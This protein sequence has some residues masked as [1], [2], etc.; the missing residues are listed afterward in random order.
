MSLFTLIV[1]PGECL[2]EQRPGR[3]TRALQPGR[4]L[5]RFG[6][7]YV[8]IDVR[9][10]LQLV[11]PQDVLTADGVIVKVTASI[12]WTVSDSVRFVELSQSPLDQ[13]YL[14][15]QV[16][17]R[18]ALVDVPVDQ[19]LSAARRGLAETLTRAGAAAG[20]ELGIEVREVVVKDVLLP[21]ELRAAYAELVTGAQKARLQLEQARAETA[22]LRSLANA[23]KLLDEHPALA[24]LR[25][26]Q[27]LPYGA[28]LSLSVDG[29]S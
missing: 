24:R 14:A 22:A 29:D 6:A 20:A 19:A 9:E 11:S 13:V 26:V 10:R 17:L 15:V 28:K 27:A 7:A 2:L 3:P 18:D 16:A 8:R 23:A 5:R 25:L 21:A 1:K 12:R 4:H